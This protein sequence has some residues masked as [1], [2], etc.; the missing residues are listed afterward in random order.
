VLPNRIPSAQGRKLLDP[1][2]DKMRAL[3]YALATEQAYVHW[4]VEFLSCHRAGGEW[5]C[6]AQEI[7]Q[8]DRNL[9]LQCAGRKGRQRNRVV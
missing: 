7:S 4:I 9:R 6:T 1:F 3:H 5:R 2:R 8:R